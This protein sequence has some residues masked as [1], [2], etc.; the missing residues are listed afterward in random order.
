MG[1]ILGDNEDM[2]EIRRI[3]GRNV[4]YSRICGR[5]VGDK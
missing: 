4:G 2:C 1:D 3:Y 5:Y